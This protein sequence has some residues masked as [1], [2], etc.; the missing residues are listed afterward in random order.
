MQRPESEDQVCMEQKVNLKE[1]T[2]E[3]VVYY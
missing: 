3:R 2:W 1:R